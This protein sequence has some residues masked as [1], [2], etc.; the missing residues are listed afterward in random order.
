MAGDDVDV[1]VEQ[2]ESDEMDSSNRVE[3]WCEEDGEKTGWSMMQ[4]WAQ[5]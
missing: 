5:G 3:E 2:G 4:R 1:R